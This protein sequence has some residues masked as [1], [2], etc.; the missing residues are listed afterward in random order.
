MTIDP[1][2]T[3]GVT[4]VSMATGVATGSIAW[5]WAAAVEGPWWVP[6]A[7]AGIGAA[8]P[9]CKHTSAIVTRL[10][11]RRIRRAEIRAVEAEASR[12]RAIREHAATR[13]EL[14]RYRAAKEGDEWLSQ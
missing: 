7:A 9:L 1:T 8:V 3:P 10:C 2:T 5:V 11:D 14:E 12:D 4:I 13:R 6:L